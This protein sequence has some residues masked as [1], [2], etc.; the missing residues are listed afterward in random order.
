MSQ[1]YQSRSTESGRSQL[2]Y[3]LSVAQLQRTRSSF[4]RHEFKSSLRPDEALLSGRLALWEPLY[5]A[6]A[7][8]F[9]DSCSPGIF[10]GD[11]NVLQGTR[12]YS[13]MALTIRALLPFA[14]KFIPVLDTAIF[15]LLVMYY[16]RLHA[17]AG[18]VDLA[19]SGYTVTIA[20]FRRY[21]HTAT[22]GATGALNIS[23]AMFCTSVALCCFEQLDE[24]AAIGFGYT[25]HLNGALQLLQSCGPN[26]VQDFPEVKPVLNAFRT[27]AAHDSIQRRRA[28]YLS[29][30]EW[31]Q[32]IFEGDGWTARD[33]LMSLAMRIPAL[34]ESV[35]KLQMGL[36]GNSSLYDRATTLLRDLHEL[37]AMFQS[38]MDGVACSIRDDLFWPSVHPKVG[39]SQVVDAECKPK[40][41]SSLQQLSFPNGSIAGLLVHYWSFQLE[42][43]A[44]EDILQRHVQTS[45]ADDGA[46]SGS[47]TGESQTISRKA[48]ETAQLIMEAQPYL[49]SCLEGIIGLQLPMESVK[50]HFARSGT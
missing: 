19:R 38:W 24:V 44:A 42:L 3:G 13:S 12:H 2:F 40:H 10:S 39:W 18:L 5:Q 33:H 14:S 27:I 8:E 16:G 50:R 31:N 47:A 49:T 1:A 45:G 48:D 26:A 32:E 22:P 29:E 17:N 43:F 25:A 34:L 37:Q 9:R 30:S 4:L 23:R 41:R 21:L 11:R 20:Q 6:I 36:C 35:D 28:T 7:A 15:S 46:R